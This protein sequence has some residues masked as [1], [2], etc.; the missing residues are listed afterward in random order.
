MKHGDIFWVDLPPTGGREQHGRRPCVVV[1]DETY[2]GAAPVVFVVPLTSAQA[3][4]RFRGVVSVQPDESNG[5]AL[6]S[7]ALVFQ[8]R[9][10]D[11]KF[12]GSFIGHLSSDDLAAVFA[13]LDRLTGR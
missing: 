7:F 12:F 13:E 2:F 5:L 11:R 6:P 1:T 4:R 3:A 8:F 9:A 10:A